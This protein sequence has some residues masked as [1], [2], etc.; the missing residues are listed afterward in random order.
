LLPVLL[1]ELSALAQMR[2]QQR[3]NWL[4]ATPLTATGYAVSG[5]PLLVPEVK[6]LRVDAQRRIALVEEA[7]ALGNGA[8]GQQPG[9]TVSP[10]ITV[11]CGAG[12]IPP[13][14]LGATPDPAA[15][16]LVDFRPKQHFRLHPTLFDV[17]T[18]AVGK[19][20]VTFRAN[21]H[22][23]LIVLFRM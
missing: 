22:R 15:L 16:A 3:F 9:D 18:E 8:I 20:P 13:E 19:L 23:W 1:G 12:P 11:G 10:A 4:V 7:L 17:G 21:V 14:V 6:V 5:V 2:M